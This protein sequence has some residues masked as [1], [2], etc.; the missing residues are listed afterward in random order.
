[1]DIDIWTLLGLLAQHGGALTWAVI[2]G[3]LLWGTAALVATIVIYMVCTRLGW[4][5]LR[6]QRSRGARVAFV[7]V[8]WLGVGPLATGAGVAYELRNATM[9]TLREEVAKRKV[10]RLVGGVLVAPML[11]SHLVAEQR[12]GTAKASAL[13]WKEL[14]THDL[15]FLVKPE[16]RG[17]AFAKMTGELIRSGTQKVPGYDQAEK[18]RILRFLVQ[19]AERKMA[20]KI[21]DKASPYAELFQDVKPDKA[22]KLTFANAADQVGQAFFRKAV[23]PAL[24]APFN[25]VIWKLLLGAVLGLGLGLG[26]I[27]LIGRKVVKAKPAPAPQGGAR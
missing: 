27:E 3:V 17:R 26:A 20:A 24:A 8:L 16:A 23:E 9:R 11:L 10:H 2:K 4:L 21:A 1:M 5:D 13:S 15:S 22:G 19:R 12:Y 6:G 18:N 25:G 7:L 14:E